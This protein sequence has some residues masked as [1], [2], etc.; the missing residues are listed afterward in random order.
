MDDPAGDPADG[1]TDGPSDDPADIPGDDP[2]PPADPALLVVAGQS[3]VEGDTGTTDVT[4][5]VTLSEAKSGPVSVDYATTDGTAV[6]GSDYAGTSGTLTFAAGE[7]S[8]TISVQVLGDTAVEADEDFSLSLSNSTGDAEISVAQASATI[9]NDDAAPIPEQP[10]ATVTFLVRQSWNGGFV[11]DLTITNTAFTALTDWDVSFNADFNISDIWGAEI[12]QQGN[13]SYT[14]AGSGWASSIA[15]GQSVTVG[16]VGRG[17]SGPDSLTALALNG[18]GDIAPEIPEAPD[19]SL[20]S[21]DDDVEAVLYHVDEIKSG[22]YT[23]SPNPDFPEVTSD[24]I[25]VQSNDFGQAGYDGHNW[26]GINPNMYRGFDYG[27]RDREV[28]ASIGNGPTLQV[29]DTMTT[30]EIEAAINGA[31]IGAT[32]EFLTGKYWLTETINVSRGDIHIKGVSEESVILRADAITSD[33]VFRV[34]EGS[35]NGKLGENEAQ[36]ITNTTGPVLAEDKTVQLQS[37]QGIEQGDFLEFVYNYN[38]EVNTRVFNGSGGS[39]D[40]ISSLVEVASVNAATNEVT[41]REKVGMDFDPNRDLGNAE[42]RV[43][44]GDDFIHNLIISDL[45]IKYMDDDDYADIV[46]PHDLFNYNNSNYGGAYDHKVSGIRLEAVH[47]SDILN[48]TIENAGSMGIWIDAG[49]QIGVRDFTFDGSQN[50]GGGGNGYAMLLD[51]SFYGDFEGLK[52]GAVDEN[53]QIAATRHA[54]V[55]GYSSSAAYN[56]IHYEF[57]NSNLDHHGGL[58]FGNISYVE[59]MSMTQT[60]HYNFGAMD[61]RYVRDGLHYNQI[62]NTYVFDNV[63]SQ[64]EGAIPGYTGS[65]VPGQEDGQGAWANNGSGSSY[66]DRVFMSANG[67]EAR[68]FGKSDELHSGAG[69]DRMWGGG[70]NDTFVFY[71]NRAKDIIYDFEAGDRIALRQNINGTGVETGNAALARL[72]QVGADAILDL[73]DGNSV[74]LA[75]VQISALSEDDFVFF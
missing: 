73:G 25:L 69:N 47:E 34:K 35:I 13:G 65:L 14:L 57:V 7:T 50:L 46:D 24:T 12:T 37:V 31:P 51:D 3:V 53:G 4:F 41:L 32:V 72:S 43:F 59:T 56:N 8:K 55:M 28:G 16:F 18:A 71:D 44:D 64:Q 11:G 19:A 54:V 61:D 52:I 68:T 20:P 38:N 33:A 30:E 66:E 27:G 63:R 75:G 67:G 10:G 48:V 22:S 60:D 5:T 29:N 2:G 62:Q 42:V 49:Y 6:A 1:P 26:G 17:G 39:F 74:T 70:G 15:A 21:M 45:T 40:K 23:P 9:T 58:D 36:L